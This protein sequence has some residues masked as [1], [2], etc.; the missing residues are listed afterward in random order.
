MEIELFR[1]TSTLTTLHYRN[2][3]GQYAWV[4][5]DLQ[6][7]LM[8]EVEVLTR[9]ALGGR[10]LIAGQQGRARRI[11]IVLDV[12][13]TSMPNLHAAIRELETHTRWRRGGTPLELRVRMEAADPW[14]TIEV[15][16][17]QMSAQFEDDQYR[18]TVTLRL[19]RPCWPA[20][21]VRP[22]SASRVS[23]SISSIRSPWKSR[24]TH[25]YCPGTLR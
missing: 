4:L 1:G 21:S 20:S 3:A 8:D 23:T 12:Q 18:A 2:L 6:G 5:R 16:L 9:D 13:G 19:A 24:N 14:D 22:P 17:E 15:V 7:D 11:V 25:E 10:T